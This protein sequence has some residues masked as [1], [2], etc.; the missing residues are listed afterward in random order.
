MPMCASI[1]ALTRFVVSFVSRW[2][3]FFSYFLVIHWL[4]FLF[5]PTPRVSAVFFPNARMNPFLSDVH[6]LIYCRPTIFVLETCLWS[7]SARAK[8]VSVLPSFRCRLF[9]SFSHGRLSKWISFHLFSLSSCTFNQ[10]IN[11]KSETTFDAADT[12]S[13]EHFA[14]YAGLLIQTVQA[15]VQTKKEL[16]TGDAT[17]VSY[18]SYV[19]LNYIK[20]CFVFIIS[21]F[22]CF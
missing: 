22:V 16:A 18:F 21:K 2:G 7:P 17:K 11:K 4:H 12:Q 13:M 1:K 3:F 20:F 5:L 14:N 6:N 10:L 19:I 15:H 9:A 8:S